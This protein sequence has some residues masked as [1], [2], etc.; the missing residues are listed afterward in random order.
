MQSLPFVSWQFH[1]TKSLTSQESEW[2]F[3]SPECCLQM[4][5]ACTEFYPRSPSTDA[6]YSHLSQSMSAAL[7]PAQACNE[8]HQQYT[9]TPA[10]NAEHM[11]IFKNTALEFLW[12]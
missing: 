6:C 7:L 12:H 4:Q 2:Q 10:T 1:L 5:T 9:M 8:Q 11:Q 3:R